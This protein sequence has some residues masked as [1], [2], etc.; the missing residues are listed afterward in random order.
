LEGN[1]AAT[2]HTN[3]RSALHDDHGF[4]VSKHPANAAGSASQTPLTM[5]ESADFERAIPHA[6]GAPCSTDSAG[7][8]QEVHSVSAI[9]VIGI[10]TLTF[11]CMQLSMA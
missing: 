7:C 11:A 6:C 9:R 4:V 2:I 10:C 3:R 5:R 8:C 1:L